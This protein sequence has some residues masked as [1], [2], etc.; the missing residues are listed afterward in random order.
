MGLVLRIFAAS[1][2]SSFA[3]SWAMSNSCH[4]GQYSKPKPVTHL[5]QYRCACLLAF[6]CGGEWRRVNCQCKALL[7]QLPV[8]LELTGSGCSRLQELAQVMGHKRQSHSVQQ[9]VKA[10]GTQ[11]A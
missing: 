3:R 11:N 1:C 5:R 10:V 8:D 6:E 9:D 7:V 2:S 4:P